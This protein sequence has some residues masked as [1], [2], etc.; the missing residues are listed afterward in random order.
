MRYLVVE[1]VSAK[2]VLEISGEVALELAA[3]GHDVTYSFV[4]ADLPW[5]DWDIPTWL[6]WFG[7]SMR[8]RV[9]H[10]EQL[11]SARGVRLH[12]CP[13]LNSETISACEQFS[14]KFTGGLNDLMR[15]RWGDAAL[16]MGVASSLISWS[17]N[18]LYDVRKNR[19]I[20]ANA[21]MSAA[22]VYQR[23]L[24]VVRAVRPEAV[25]LFN[26]RFGTT[27]PIVEAARIESAPVIRYERGATYDKYELF[28]EPL[29]DFSYIRRRIGEAWQ[30]AT[31]PGRERTA[32]SFFARRRG[33]DGI[34]W[35]SY[36]AQQRRG[37]VPSRIPG[38]FRVVYFSS[39]D[40]EY[41]AIS[42]T[43][44]AG[45]W[46][47]QISAVRDL[48]LTCEAVKNIELIIRV[49]PHL[50]KKS[51]ADQQ[52]W[53]ELRGSQT[54]LIHA[55]SSVDSYALLD[56]AD[57]VVTYGSTIGIE[58]T[59][60]GKPSVLVGPSVYQGLG[61]AYEPGGRD[62]LAGL[63]GRT[64][65]LPSFPQERCLPY[66]HYYLTY[67]WPYKYYAPKSL[68]DGEFLGERLSW[69]SPPVELFRRFGAG[70][71]YTKIKQALR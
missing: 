28:S 68:M 5:D 26:G 64:A 55:E 65:S 43:V 17:G 60:W 10:F 13:E 44:P 46:Q 12:A 67:G 62:E 63:I 54:R 59:Y 31:P 70:K 38:K 11:L 48:I 34:G 47:N 66:G 15:Y 69:A 24:G 4:G 40:D 25:A 16:G 18:S 9:K 49:H 8:P 36:V 14:S 2:P 27:K 51:S 23:A 6:K 3:Q 22:I 42:D 61:V 21:L 20:V 1:S 37:K 56:S 41:A 19:K 57:V 71:V 35:F 30:T 45:A 32:H 7:C 29:H 39:S 52:R 33:G 50:A 58:A 53:N